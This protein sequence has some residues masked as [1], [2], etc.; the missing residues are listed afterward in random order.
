MGFFKPGWMSR[1]EG[2][3]L[4]SLDKIS[5]DEEL[6]RIVLECPHGSVRMRALSRIRDAGRRL[7][8]VLTAQAVSFDER[9]AA[10]EGATEEGLCRAAREAPSCGIRLEAVGRMTDSLLLAELVKEGAGGSRDDRRVCEA[11]YEKMTRPPFECSM[12]MRGRKAEEN[13]M[14]DIEEMVYPDDRDRLLRAA[15]ERDGESGGRD[16]SALPYDRERDALRDMA[17]NGKGPARLTAL[18]RLRLPSDRDIVDAILS[19]PGSGKV[20]KQRAARLLP[21]NDPVLERM[22]C[23]FCGAIESVFHHGGYDEGVDMYYSAFECRSCGR[24]VRKHSVT[25]T[26]SAKDFSIRLRELING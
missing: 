12:L 26:A 15:R 7:D 8:L 11:A 17:L 3:A 22:C 9:L 13:L 16:V 19:D 10:L 5:R 14:R 6:Y 4:R 24:E 21:E 25:G 20:L 18:A 2:K 23:P 1:D